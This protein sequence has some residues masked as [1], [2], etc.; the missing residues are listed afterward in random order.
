M[1]IL[2]HANAFQVRDE[3]EDGSVDHEVATALIA[4]SVVIGCFCKYSE[5]KHCILQRK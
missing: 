5:W 2:G 1:R 4:E 3:R